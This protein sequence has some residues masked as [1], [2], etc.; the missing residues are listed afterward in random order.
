MPFGVVD[1]SHE[2][3][4]LMDRVFGDLKGKVAIYMDDF[5][6]HGKTGKEANAHMKETL[7]RLRR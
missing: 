2:F 4:L 3:Q 5:T 1:G 7:Q 6:P